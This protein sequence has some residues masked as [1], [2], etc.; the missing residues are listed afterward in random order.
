[1]IIENYHFFQLNAASIKGMIWDELARYDAD[2]TG[3]A[4][5]AL[6]SSG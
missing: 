2:K 5:H 6:E 1:M 3:M 4:D